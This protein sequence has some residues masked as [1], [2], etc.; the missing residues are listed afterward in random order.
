MLLS[1]VAELEPKMLRPIVPDMV[2]TLVSVCNT[3][4]SVRQPR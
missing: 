3:E 2:E 4:V 1:Q